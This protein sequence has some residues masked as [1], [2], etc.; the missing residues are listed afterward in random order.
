MP[1]KSKKSRTAETK[2]LKIKYVDYKG[3]ERTYV[4]D[5]LV[6]EKEL[7]EAYLAAM[8]VNPSGLAPN[9]MAEEV[10]KVQVAINERIE[11]LEREK[12]ISL[13]RP[14]QE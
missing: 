11:T 14:L 8:D 12:I 10:D 4:A 2:D 13:E 6:E 3:D 1:R 7:I 5:F 9:Y